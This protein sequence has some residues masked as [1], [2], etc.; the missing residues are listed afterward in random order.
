MD[1]DREVNQGD[2]AQERVK[3]C[4]N[5]LEK[6][7]NFKEGIDWKTDV[8]NRLTIEEMIG[9]LVSAE[10]YIDGWEKERMRIEEVSLF[11]GK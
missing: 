4:L 2:T 1:I 3:F 10:Q 7:K 5:Q 9:A 11:M 8:V 6:A